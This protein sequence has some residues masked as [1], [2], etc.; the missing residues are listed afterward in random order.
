MTQEIMQNWLAKRAQLSP[1]RLAIVDG[2]L[3]WTF[4][5]LY[6]MVQKTAK[7]LHTAGIQQGDFVALLLTNSFRAPQLIHSVAQASAVT[8]LLNSRLTAQEIAW[9]LADSPTKLL[10][11]DEEFAAVAQQAVVLARKLLYEA[12]EAERASQFSLLSYQELSDLPET[13]VTFPAHVAMSEVHTLLYTSGTTGTPKGVLLTYGNHWWSAVGSALNLGLSASDRWLVCVPLFHMSGLSILL[14]SLI[15]GIPAIIH[16][17]FLP[18]AVNQAILSEGITLVSVVS[19][20]LLR[21][22]DGLGERSYPTSFRCMLVGGGPV[23]PELLT[24][25]RNQEIPVF[26]TYGLTETASQLATLAPEYM[27]QKL[28]S[29]GKALFPAEIK[30]VTENGEAMAGEA[31]EILVRG[32]SVTSG[33]LKDRGS[34]SFLSGSWLKTGDLGYFDAAGFLYVLDRRSDLIISGGENVYPAE[35]EAVLVKHAAVLEA[36][37]TAMADLVWGQ[38]PAAFVV[39]RQGAA[40]TELE[41]QSFCRSHLAGYK[42][43]KRVYVISQLPRNGAN[44]LVRRRLQELVPVIETG[45]RG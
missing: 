34:D 7:R 23:P 29:A 22:V 21:L 4:Q 6:E 28:G 16:R 24:R 35:I 2:E 39:L 26:Q 43:P 32:P 1:E 30:I 12:N 40:V 36:G 9:Q 27:D 25:C 17:K 38:V 37:V 13:S 45:Q 41:L 10:I 11:Y 8:V 44:K 20:M 3:R 19:A 42:C 15:Y 33:Y 14:R 18:S 5:E 31:G